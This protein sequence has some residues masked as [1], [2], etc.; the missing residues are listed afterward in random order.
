MTFKLVLTILTTISLTAC[1]TSPAKV[2]SDYQTDPNSSIGMNILKAAGTPELNVFREVEL[3]DE[4]YAKVTETNAVGQGVTAVGIG[5][6]TSSALMVSAGNSLGSALSTSFGK[7]SMG[8]LFGVG[9]LGAMAAPT[10]PMLVD[11]TMY[12][13]PQS[14]ANSESEAQEVVMSEL[15]KATMSVAEGYQTTKVRHG[16]LLGFNY[17]YLRLDTDICSDKNCL[18]G[19]EKD[20]FSYETPSDVDF[21]LVK[22]PSFIA[23]DSEY[24]WVGRY[25][26]Y[27]WKE[28]FRCKT[29]KV[30]AENRALCEYH[31][32]QVKDKFY[33]ALP[34]WLY[35]YTLD[36]DSRVGVVYQGGTGVAYPLIK[37]KS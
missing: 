7:S 16:P 28:Q 26:R 24:V 34:T 37:K 10:N 15:Y 20:A 12:F 9:V 23:G 8:S 22:R 14:M 27:V 25:D 36:R 1:V 18:A 3:S 17:D 29:L 21:K 35:R 31:N 13:V 33:K 5:V 32:E 2:S 6:A 19:L 11:R 30:A 4:D